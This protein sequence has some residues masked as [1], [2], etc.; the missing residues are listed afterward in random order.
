MEPVPESRQVNGSSWSI[1]VYCGSYSLACDRRLQNV[2]SMSRDVDDQA[3]RYRNLL[4]QYDTEDRQAANAEMFAPALAVVSVGVVAA[5]L[6]AH[7]TIGVTL[8]ITGLIAGLVWR[9]DLKAK[10]A[11]RSKL[12]SDVRRALNSVTPP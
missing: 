7:E 9:S 6:A 2:R 8:G 5:S 10:S 12:R 4:A 3:T 11:A 1:P